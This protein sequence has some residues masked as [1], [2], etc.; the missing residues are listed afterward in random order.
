MKVGDRIVIEP[1]KALQPGRS[2]VIEEVLQESPARV[3]VRWDDGRSSILSPAAGVARITSARA[4]KAREKAAAAKAEAESA[5]ATAA[6]K[7][8]SAASKTA[9]KTAAKSAA[10]KAKAKA[11]PKK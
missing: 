3:S 5:T 6:P 4:A 2:G 1:K 7:A 9:S 8:K 10:P 11:K